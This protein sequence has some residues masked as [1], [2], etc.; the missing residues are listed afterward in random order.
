[1]QTGQETVG[2][3]VSVNSRLQTATGHKVVNTNL[4]SVVVRALTIAEQHLFFL[5]LVLFRSAVE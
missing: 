5:L 2:K 3:V 4:T 1:M